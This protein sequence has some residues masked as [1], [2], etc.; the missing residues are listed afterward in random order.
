MW[1]FSEIS[2]SNYKMYQIPNIFGS[3]F[4]SKCNMTRAVHVYNAIHTWVHPSSFL[5]TL[6][7]ARACLCQSLLE[8]F[9]CKSYYLLFLSDQ[10]LYVCYVGKTMLE[11]VTNFSWFLL[12]R[13]S[14]Y[15]RT[16][17]YWLD[18]VVI[19]NAFW[20]LHYISI[21][22]KEI[23]EW[24]HGEVSQRLVNFCKKIVLFINSYPLT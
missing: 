20:R 10:S 3:Q 13:M 12:F 17:S 24:F 18:H 7:L 16:I 6:L 21:I 9:D 4:G 22:L 23:L 5:Y 15:A 19:Y 11:L 8:C 2:C 14:K 1:Y